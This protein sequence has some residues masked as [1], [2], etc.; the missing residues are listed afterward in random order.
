MSSSG[1]AHSSWTLFHE[2][3]R[4]FE[5]ERL[6][7]IE[8][9]DNLGDDQEENEEDDPNKRDLHPKFCMIM[10][11][12]GRPGVEVEEANDAAEEY[13]TFLEL[14]PMN[15]SDVKLLLKE[16]L[17]AHKHIEPK[18]R[19]ARSERHEEQ[20]DDA[21]RIFR[22]LG[23]LP[24]RLS[25]RSSLT[26][27]RSSQLLEFVNDMSEGNP[28]LICE[29]AHSILEC[30]VCE[31]VDGVCKIR[32]GHTTHEIKLNSKLRH[33]VLQEFSTLS[34]H[35]QLIAKIASVYTK[36]FS[37]SMLEGHVEQHGKDHED[38]HISLSACI[39][40]LVLSEVFTT[41][42]VPG[43]MARADSK[44]NEALKFR[45]KLM[46]KAV[47]ELLLESHM[48]SVAR[49]VTS[50]SQAR[51]ISAFWLQ[52]AVEHEVRAMRVCASDERF[53]NTLPLASMSLSCRSPRLARRTTSSR[54]SWTTFLRAGR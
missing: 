46:Q 41:C 39:S 31:I 29:L 50:V 17:Q 47:T 6:A 44:A 3:R 18:V 35:E 13:E 1:I 27:F 23:S 8:R 33:M 22:F 34:L 25:L 21:L 4:G 42:P 51:R 37:S 10:N 15:E 26:P 28:R 16:K 14:D 11:H 30:D 32:P 43:W 20:S 45:S 54:S 12:M 19:G 5:A 48:T 40:T 7:A 49:S 38:T 24:S 36:E 9:L 53:T 52:R 2:L